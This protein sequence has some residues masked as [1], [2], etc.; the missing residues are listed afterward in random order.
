MHVAAK[1]RSVAVRTAKAALIRAKCALFAAKKARH[2]PLGSVPNYDSKVNRP[3]AD[4]PLSFCSGYL[5]LAI[6]ANEKHFFGVYIL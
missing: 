6:D 2:N 5:I 3:Y 4:S 1:A